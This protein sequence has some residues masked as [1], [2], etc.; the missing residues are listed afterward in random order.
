MKSRDR[1]DAD[2]SIDCVW[3]SSVAD[4]DIETIRRPVLGADALKES[5][6]ALRVAVA[7]PCEIGDRVAWGDGQEVVSLEQGNREEVSGKWLESRWRTNV[8]ED[9][10][11]VADGYDNW[12]LYVV[13]VDVDGK[14]TFRVVSA[15]AIHCSCQVVFRI[16][17]PPTMRSTL[18]AAALPLLAVAQVCSS[19]GHSVYLVHNRTSSNLP[20]TTARRSSR[21]PPF[22][23][24]SV[25]APT[26]KP[27]PAPALLFSPP[28]R[29][30]R[31]HLSLRAMAPSAM[32]PF[33]AT[34][35]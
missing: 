34:A 10:C 17:T 28:Q 18:L 19:L 20:K 6:H 14:R 3:V 9:S 29:S 25:L 32:A 13:D 1:V 33:R 30:S 27:A 21:L 8:V 4:L 22:R 2:V 12:S 31:Q 26:D 16:L 24:L 7:W 5:E 23:P 11:D 15:R 35:Q